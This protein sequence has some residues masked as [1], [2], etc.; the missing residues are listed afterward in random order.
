MILS[1]KQQTTDFDRRFG[2]LCSWPKTTIPAAR[3]HH[4]YHFDRIARA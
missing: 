3:S 2:Q 4:S 1:S